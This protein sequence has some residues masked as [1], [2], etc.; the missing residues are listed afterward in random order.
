MDKPDYD[1]II[2]KNNKNIQTKYLAV[3]IK[4]PITFYI[5]SLEK[6]ILY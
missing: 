1:F 6:S 5:S 3:S 2:L 4:Q